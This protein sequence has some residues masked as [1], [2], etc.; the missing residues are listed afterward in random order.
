MNTD[1]NKKMEFLQTIQQHG[2]DADEIW[3]ILRETT[4]QSS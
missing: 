1:S 4:A 3:L 2:R